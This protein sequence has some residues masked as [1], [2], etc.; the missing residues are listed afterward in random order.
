MG[1]VATS[2]HQM[3]RMKS[4]ASPSTVKADPEDFL[5]HVNILDPGQLFFPWPNVYK[6]AMKRS[7][8]SVAQAVQAQVVG[9]GAVE[10]SGIASIAQ[11]T[12]VD[13]VF[14]EDEKSLRAA[15][16]FASRGGHRG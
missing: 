15:L 14:V 13:L 16:G 11:A 3:G 1:M 4:A 5:L 12:P 2:A 8:L 9:D 7:L 10:V 6:G